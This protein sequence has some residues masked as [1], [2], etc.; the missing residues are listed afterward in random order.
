[1]GPADLTQWTMSCT[2]WVCNDWNDE[3][4]SVW[5]DNAFGQTVYEHTWGGGSALWTPGGSWRAY[6]EAL[7]WNDRV[8]SFI[9]HG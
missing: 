6:L 9:S 1:M 2:L 7:G 8:S 4:S 5:A 3:T